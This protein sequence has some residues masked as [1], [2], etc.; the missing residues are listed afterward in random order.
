MQERLDQE[1]L[2]RSR[3]ELQSLTNL[4]MGCMWNGLPRLKNPV[5]RHYICHQ[6]CCMGRITKLQSF[7]S[8]CIQSKDFDLTYCSLA[9]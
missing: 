5:I 9:A 8:V 6:L 7:C 4:Y 2:C 1:V 3:Y